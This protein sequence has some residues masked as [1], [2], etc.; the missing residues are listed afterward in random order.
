MRFFGKRSSHDCVTTR[1]PSRFRGATPLRHLRWPNRS[2]LPPLIDDNDS[3]QDN[4]SFAFGIY[5]LQQQVLF[6]R[7]S[8]II[9][10]DLHVQYV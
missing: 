6:L 8:L 4:L 10:L 1:L 9:L 2:P 5:E 7:S 3:D